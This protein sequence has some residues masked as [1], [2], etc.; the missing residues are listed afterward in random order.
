MMITRNLLFLFCVCCSAVSF[1]VQTGSDAKS[2]TRTLISMR[3]A[4]EMP[5]T[6][7][8]LHNPAFVNVDFHKEPDYGGHKV[9]RG[10]VY[11]AAPR[12]FPLAY[13]WDQKARTL[14][15]DH[16]HNLDLTDETTRP[17][18]SSGPT[19]I[20]TFDFGTELTSGTQHRAVGL[21]FI[22]LPGAT[23]PQVFSRCGW[24]GKVQT[25]LGERTIWLQGDAMGGFRDLAF[26]G[27]ATG[28]VQL[29][30][31][32]GNA[33][34]A[35]GSLEF[36]WAVGARVYHA[37]FVPPSDPNSDR[38]TAVV[39][40]KHVESGD[41]EIVGE[42]LQSIRLGGSA[43]V[44]I[45]SPTSIVKVPVGHYNYAQITLAAAGG[46]TTESMEAFQS[47]SL[48][49]AKNRSAKLAAGGPLEQ[50][51]TVTRQGNVLTLGYSL[52]GRGGEAYRPAG[53]AGEGVAFRILRGGKQIAAGRMQYG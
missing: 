50:K 7:A 31:A 13:A 8:Y 16:N 33:H 28:N 5:V 53:A 37:S 44:V 49:I 20:Q 52:T 24:S 21:R 18:V 43:T 35:T 26:I 9:V 42:N 45:D 15:I 11:L 34:L 23:N 51:A 38:V 32:P 1:G 19:E 30:R 17:V 3:Y 27:S 48:E 14:Y 22:F 2:E 46:G 25:D 40:E 29:Q 41:L 10:M 36:T 47:V 4:P 12:S 39:S 6:A